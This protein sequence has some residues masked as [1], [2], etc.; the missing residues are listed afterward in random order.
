MKK[1]MLI[2]CLAIFS[3]F[4]NA[5][6]NYEK[7][8][9]IFKEKDSTETLTFLKKWEKT[10]PN[11]PELYTC[12]FNFYFAES[13]QEILSLETKQSGKESLTLKDSTGQAEVFL[14]TQQGWEPKKLAKALDY[15]NLGIKKF[16]DRLDM[17][18]GKTYV[19]GELGRYDEFSKEIIAAI[20]HADKIKNKWLWT[21][22]EPKEDAEKFM[23]SAMQAYFVQ[24]YN[25]EDD[26]LLDNME[27]ISQTVL[28]YHPDHV[29]SLSNLSIIYTI[30]KNYDKGLEVL[31]KAEKLA[32]KDYIV[33]N[34]IAN[35]YRKKGDNKKAIKYYKLTAKYCNDKT[36]E[37]EIE[38]EI[39][40]LK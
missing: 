40:K 18:F 36:V 28:K 22:N 37:Q 14:K 29:E 10:N 4:A 26:R 7:F 23:L 15:I 17:R 35:I 6:S 19:L 11:D 25:T 1:S 16:P 27:K 12:A 5:Q 24:L 33:L 31:L 3:S 39:A 2:L 8:K 30:Q 21:E 20:E 32:P 13:K 34:N 9:T 38:A